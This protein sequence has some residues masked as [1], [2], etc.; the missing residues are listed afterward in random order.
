[1]DELTERLVELEIRYTHQNRMIEELNEELTA[2]NER[3]D[4]LTREVAGLRDM[5]G[6]LGPDLLESPDE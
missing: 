6:S 1:M 5:L 3:I 4:R 2:A